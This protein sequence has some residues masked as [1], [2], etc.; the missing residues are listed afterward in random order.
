MTKFIFPKNEILPANKIFLSIVSLD[1]WELIKV[2]G[3]DKK[4]YLNSQITADINLLKSNK[5][6]LCGHCNNKGKIY[7]TLLIF[8]RKKN[9]F[10]ILRKNIAK[11]QIQEIKKYSIFSIV[12]F[13]K[14]KKL[15]FF[16]VL[17]KNARNFLKNFFSILPN[18]HNSVIHENNITVIFIYNVIERFIL[19]SSYKVLVK[20]LKK[21]TNISYFNSSNQWLS[22]DIEEKIPIIES[23][24]LLNFF[25]QEINLDKF[26]NS[27]S[28]KKGCY[29]GQEQIV[30]IKYNNFNKRS[31]KFL[32]CIYDDK[33]SFFPG[34]LV[35]VKIKKKWIKKGVL[36]SSVTVHNKIY[37]QVVLNKIYN[38]EKIYKIRSNYFHVKK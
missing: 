28:Y 9:Y 17:G 29:L 10:Y 18:K 32:Y 7:S 8:K 27:I 23:Q 13:S 35:Y 30:K 25:P 31:L 3:Q 20:I 5:Y 16:G 22:I 34:D 37:A 26:K 24:N 12:K 4:K 6:I 19:V 38:K 15:F 14:E 21:N 33:N 2:S 1:E 36:L 11:K